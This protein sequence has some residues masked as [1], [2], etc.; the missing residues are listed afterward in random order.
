MNAFIQD[1]INGFGKKEIIVFCGAGISF[2]SGIPL[3]WDIK[4]RILETLNLGD[5]EKNR[6][7]EYSQPFE[8]FM[9]T[10]IERTNPLPLFR[11]FELGA[12][13]ITHLFLAK[14]AKNQLID[15]VVTTNFDKLIET[16]MDDEGVDYDT[17]YEDKQLQDLKIGDGMVR[18]IKLHG[19]VHNKNEMAVTIKKV[20]ENDSIYSRKKAIDEII[21][22]KKY[23]SILM[24]GYSCSDVFDINPSLS[25]QENKKKQIIY[26]RHSDKNKSS[27]EPLANP[28]E[29]YLG[30]MVTHNTDAV[31]K[32]IW[33]SILSCEC[34]N[35]AR[36]K[37]HW[38][39][40]VTDWARM[41]IENHGRDVL[42][43]LAGS[44]FKYSANF[45]ESNKYLLK[46]VN[47]DRPGDCNEIAVYACQSIGDNYRDTGEY[48]NAIDYFKKA[49]DLARSLKMSEAQCV[50]INSIGI[51]YEDQKKHDKA[52]QKHQSAL[53]IAKRQ[54]LKKMEGKILGNIGI[55]L[56]NR[57]GKDS[58]KKA[59][60]YQND[61]LNIARDIGDKRS[62]GRTLGNLAIA[63]SDS[64]DK[65]TAIEYYKEAYNVAIDLADVYH[66]AVWKANMGMDYTGTDNNMAEE[67][68]NRAIEQFQDI[69]SQHYVEYCRKKLQELYMQ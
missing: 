59:I 1:L 61:A 47:A 7:L 69:G 63:Y 41:A 16:A 57:G 68:L 37:L 33:E 53:K 20:A 10:I 15:T 44:L 46:S 31:I 28:F 40:A 5:H 12:P 52:I 24:I 39:N 23:K 66:Q 48:S 3:V 55:V 67:Y 8:A 35:V 43:F 65:S 34:P 51:V 26:L 49:M 14:M 13:G 30:R 56:K 45:K 42:E 9:E 54:K 25:S 18:I 29:G 19:S 21:A 2:N 50:A 27:S 62:E 22:N 58:L 64:G 36:V 6:L 32:T 38:E 4:S 17:V 11:M 60:E